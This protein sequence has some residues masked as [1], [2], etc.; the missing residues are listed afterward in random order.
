MTSD[1]GTVSRQV[2]P[3]EFEP[4]GAA[5]PPGRQAVF[6]VLSNARRRYAVRFLLQQ[7]EPVDLRRLSEQVA[8]WET[9][10]P[11]GDISATERHRVYN[12]LQQAHLP[13]MARAGA[14][15]VDRGRVY[16]TE[17]LQDFRVYMEVVPRNEIPWSAF[18]AALGGIALFLT[19]ALAVGAYP[20]RTVPAIVYLGLLA[21]VLTV[22]GVIHVYQQRSMRLDLDGD[23]DE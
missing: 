1:G 2:E 10:K 5:T 7:G 15:R 18:Y 4:D 8:A 12:A 21:T 14:V 23:P 9:G 3:T 16:P 11:V 17:A 22:S 6:E 19:A 13:K 20:L